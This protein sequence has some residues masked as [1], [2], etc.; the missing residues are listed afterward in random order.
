MSIASF[1]RSAGRRLFFPLVLLGLAAACT[2]TVRPGAGSAHQYA[3]RQTVAGAVLPISLRLS[4]WGAGGPAVDRYQR[5]RLE[6]ALSPEGPWTAWKAVRV[7]VPADRQSDP[8]FTHRF[9]PQVPATF[10][11]RLFFRFVLAFDGQEQVVPGLN[12]IEVVRPRP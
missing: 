9:E 12:P 11:G 2:P 1:L 10:E 7:D 3:P 5:V 4:T 8:A 6:T